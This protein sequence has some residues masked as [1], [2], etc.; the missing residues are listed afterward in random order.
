MEPWGTK[1]NLPHHPG[2]FQ[3]SQHNPILCYG[4]NCVPSKRH[5][6]SSRLHKMIPIWCWVFKSHQAKLRLLTR[7]DSVLTEE[8]KQTLTP[9]GKD[10]VK[11][12]A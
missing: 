10:G 6:L 3:W 9:Q 7:Y 2:T 8:G 11:T 4:M 5:V 1:T 12:Q